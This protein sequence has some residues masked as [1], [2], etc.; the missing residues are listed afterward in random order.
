MIKSNCN[1]NTEQKC[2]IYKKLLNEI[3]IKEKKQRKI[4]IIQKY[5]N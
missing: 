4:K 3:K 5:N 2:Y 1:G